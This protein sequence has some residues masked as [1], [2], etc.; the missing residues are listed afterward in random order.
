MVFST[1]RV[2]PASKHKVPCNHN[3]MQTFHIALSLREKRRAAVSIFSTLS[4]F[5]DANQSER[6]ELSRL[7]RT[8]GGSSRLRIAVTIFVRLIQTAVTSNV[9]I[10]ISTLRHHALS[11]LCQLSHTCRGIVMIGTGTALLP[12]SPGAS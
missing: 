5:A 6:H 10:V 12:N 3:P 7:V 2:P 4:A 11:I 8:E 9:P 1:S